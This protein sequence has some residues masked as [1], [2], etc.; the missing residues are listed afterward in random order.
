MNGS[1]KNRE[2]GVRSEHLYFF[3]DQKVTAEEVRQMLRQGTSNQRAWVISH[4]LRYAQWDDI[5][6][7]VSRDEVKEIFPALDLPENLR[8]AW[9]R[10]L[11]I[12]APVA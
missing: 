12:E 6:A 11:K 4:L 9:G 7:Y 10:M 5:W 3:P 8:L 2:G 1:G